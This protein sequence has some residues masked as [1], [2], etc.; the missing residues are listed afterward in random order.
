MPIDYLAQSEKYRP[1]SI[2]RLLVGEAPPPS[3]KA[4][5]YF[6]RPM[7]NA[8]PIE[9]DSSLP[10]TIFYHYF[11]KRPSNCEDYSEHLRA[12]Q[13]MGVFL[14]DICDDPIKVRKCPE[15]LQRIIQ[16]IPN[17]RNKMRARGIEVP[18]QDIVFLLARNNYQS[19]IRHEFP[20]SN[21]IRWKD[22]RM[23]PE[24]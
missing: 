3:G 16:E 24:A 19:H 15:G 12:L 17:L 10:A 1:T 8:K 23:T 6:P 2:E 5:F 13:D 4:Y 9:K 21:R 22:F 7:S 11:Q 18:D 20:N 14:I